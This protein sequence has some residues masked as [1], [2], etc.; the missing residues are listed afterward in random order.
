MGISFPQL[1]KIIL[2]WFF[3]F[4]FLSDF[5]N[6]RFFLLFFVTHHKKSREP[7]IF[8]C[9]NH[10]ISQMDFI[11][12]FFFVAVH[13]TVNCLL[14]SQSFRLPSPLFDAQNLMLF[15][16]NTMRFLLKKIVENL[17]KNLSLYR[18]LTP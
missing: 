6:E 9:T 2:V 16:G 8:Y 12:L 17:T 10:H 3:F 14:Q 13:F 5:N 7:T 1:F 11:L 15:F 4:F 18:K